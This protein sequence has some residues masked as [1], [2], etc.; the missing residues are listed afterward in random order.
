[1]H[2]LYFISQWTPCIYLSVYLSHL[3]IIYPF[4]AVSSSCFLLTGIIYLSIYPFIHLSI[5]LSTTYTWIFHYLSF[6]LSIHLSIYLSRLRKRRHS[7]HLKKHGSSIKSTS[8]KVSKIV[9]R[10]YD[11]C[12]T[13]T[14]ILTENKMLMVWWQFY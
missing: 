11:R 12:L 8:T 3:S 7:R 2:L 6:W 5:I 10:S 13:C 4:Y 14:S 9:H 1:M